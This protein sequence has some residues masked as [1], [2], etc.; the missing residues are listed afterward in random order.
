MLETT[1]EYCPPAHLQ[2]ETEAEAEALEILLGASYDGVP[3]ASA[4]SCRVRYVL[5][6]ESSV[7][8]SSGGECVAP[9]SPAPTAAPVPPSS[10]SPTTEDAMPDIGGGGSGGSGA[11]GPA[12]F[13]GAPDGYYYEDGGYGSG[14]GNGTVSLPSPSPGQNFLSQSVVECAEAWAN[15]T[16]VAANTTYQQA[17][18]GCT[19]LETLVGQ[20]F[21]FFRA[22]AGM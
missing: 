17:A 2:L 18:T 15:C 1:A 3:C 13:G 22:V 12:G 6:W 20:V 11:P 5:E 21:Y 10:P 19:K 8:A 7:P 4:M 9:P 14:S 16:T